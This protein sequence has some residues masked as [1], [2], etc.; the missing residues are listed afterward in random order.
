M[1]TERWCPISDLNRDLQP[2]RRTGTPI[3][4]PA[5]LNVRCLI[6]NLIAGFAGHRWLLA[7]GW[8]QETVLKHPVARPQK[9]APRPRLVAPGAMFVRQ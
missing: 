2:D 8:K 6:L 1:K 5:T 4:T 3:G 9:L 7:A